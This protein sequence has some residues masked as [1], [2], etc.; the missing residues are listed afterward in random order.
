MAREIKYNQGYTTPAPRDFVGNYPLEIPEA[1]AIYD[2]TASNNFSLML[3]YHTQGEVIYWKFLD[4]NPPNAQLYGQLFENISG[5]PLQSTPYNSSF[6]G[7]KDWFIEEYNH[8]GFTV[9]IGKGQNPLPAET[10]EEIYLKIREIQTLATI[11]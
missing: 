8:P 2:L 4:Y 7:F 10:A 6:A 3:T 1:I 5:Y 9:E 11:I